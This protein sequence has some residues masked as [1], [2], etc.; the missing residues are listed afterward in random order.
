MTQ[1]SPPACGGRLSDAD[2]HL[3][4][5]ARELAALRTTAAVND[6]FPGWADTAA[7]YAE[8]FGYARFIAG[9]LAGLAERLAAG[10]GE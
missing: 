6:R 1:T 9:E 5:R 3:I 8:A 7:A 2:R 10:D 4:A